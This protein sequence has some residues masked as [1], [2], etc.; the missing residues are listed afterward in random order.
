[1]ERSRPSLGHILSLSALTLV[2]GF[3]V[4]AVLAAPASLYAPY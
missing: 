1:M 3:L 2:V 4:C